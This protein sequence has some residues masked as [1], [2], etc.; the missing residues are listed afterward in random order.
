[1]HRHIL[2][3][4][5]ELPQGHQAGREVQA[6]RVCYL[7]FRVGDSRPRPGLGTPPL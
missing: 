5:Y 4:R 6:D 1:M 3:C 7:Q 2:R